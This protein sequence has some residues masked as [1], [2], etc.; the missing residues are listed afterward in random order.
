MTF[1]IRMVELAAAVVILV[2]A[3]TAI[4]RTDEFRAFF[5]APMAE[6]VEPD[7]DDEFVRV[8]Q[9]MLDTVEAD[10][11]ALRDASVAIEHLTRQLAATNA[12]VQ[13]L[14]SGSSDQVRS[15]AEAVLSTNAALLDASAQVQRE[16]KA[17][18]IAAAAQTKSSVQGRDLDERAKVAALMRGTGSGDE[19]GPDPMEPRWGIVFGSEL[20]ED[21]AEQM[22]SRA[23]ESGSSLPAM[24]LYR[25]N[26]FYRG[27]AELPT[28][29]AALQDL[30]DIRERVRSDA[31]IISLD[32]WCPGPRSD[33]GTVEC[34]S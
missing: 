3:W 15:R 32:Q 1:L 26:G 16:A 21:A 34:G 14:L 12:V 23:E 28:Y 33:Q 27:V 8:G 18:A 4:Y 24:R 6:Q 11:A 25:R 10:H 22:L 31:Y 29:A 5:A 17:A 9:H 20:T 19:A 30:P 13:D 2:V 7:G